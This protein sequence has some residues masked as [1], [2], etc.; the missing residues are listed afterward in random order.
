MKLKGIGAS[1]GI[2]IAKVFELVEAHI[3]IKDTKISDI[4]AEQA[5]VDKAIA[6]AITEIESVKEK[7]LKN[8]GEHEAAVFDAH[9]QVAADPSLAEEVKNMIANESVNAIF[10]TD[11]VTKNFA[12]MFESMEDAYMRERAA[13]IKDVAKRILYALA[14]VKQA[15]VAN[16]NEEVIIVAHDLTPSDTAQLNKKYVKGFVTNIGGR[17]SHAAIMARSLEIPAV[18]GLKDVTSKTKDNEMI[19]LDGNTGEVLINPSASE[20][21]AFKAKAE[22]EAKEKAENKTFIGK[23]STTKDGFEVL[24]E[25][26]IGSPKDTVGANEND[27]EGVGLFRSEFLYMDAKD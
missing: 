15:S 3:E 25:A 2:A 5:K 10:A 20:L 24:L 27:A 22:A 12:A 14:G 6:K 13:D 21:N 7:A 4:N 19:A 8:L 16:I 18:L 23:K 17:T 26:N 11:V 1:N 9:I